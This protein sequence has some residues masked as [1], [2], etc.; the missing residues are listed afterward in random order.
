M[1]EIS[2]W[3]DSQQ[4]AIR[5]GLEVNEKARTY[6]RDAYGA[7]NGTEKTFKLA[8]LVLPECLKQ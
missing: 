1:Y 7:E 8:V 6:V 4:G 2:S 3:T 5:G